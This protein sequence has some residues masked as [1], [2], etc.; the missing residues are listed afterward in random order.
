MV[1]QNRLS[2]AERILRHSI[3]RTYTSLHSF[4]NTSKSAIQLNNRVSWRVTKTKNHL[5]R[6]HTVVF[7]TKQ[8]SLM[9]SN[10]TQTDFNSVGYP[11][12]S[13]TCFSMYLGHPQSH[14]YKNS[15][16]EDTIRI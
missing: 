13:A 7:I 3:F 10:T 2:A 14:K 12:M 11:Y 5:Y 4:F 16:K 15:T 8:A 6:S 1:K 9:Q